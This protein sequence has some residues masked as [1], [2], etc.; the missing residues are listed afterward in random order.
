MIN[1]DN[2]IKKYLNDVK[3]NL[4]CSFKTKKQILSSV[5][6]SVY[7]YA[8]ENN[9]QDIKGI[10][11]HFG[12]PLEIAQ[13]YLPEPDIRI[14]KINVILKRLILTVMIG[15]ILWLVFFLTEMLI[16][17]YQSRGD[18]TELQVVQRIE[19]STEDCSL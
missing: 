12:T 2:E 11:S 9:I 15:F 5:K 10:Y 19:Y 17:N 3:K 18:Y 14:I 1:L 13:V 16:I 8:E 6:S 4:I 7:D